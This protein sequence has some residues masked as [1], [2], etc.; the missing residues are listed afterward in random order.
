MRRDAQLLDQF[1]AAENDYAVK[2]LQVALLDQAAL[3]HQL[4]RDLFAFF[5]ARLQLGK[6]HFDP[7]LLEDV[8][9][10]ALWQPPLQRHLAAFKTRAARIAG[11][12]FLPLMAA[13]RSLTEP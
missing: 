7:D 12:R 10:A 4:G 9:E 11:T 6:L 8:G 5:E 1:V 13:P 3:G 2:A